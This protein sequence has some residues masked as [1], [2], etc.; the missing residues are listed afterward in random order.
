MHV[1]LIPYGIKSCVDML[2]KEM[3][4]QKFPLICKKEGEPDRSMLIQGSVR[5]SPFGLVEYVF[6]KESLDL[7]LHTF[8][9]DTVHYSQ[10]GW[11]LKFLLKFLKK[12][13]YLKEIPKY[14]KEKEF[15]WIRDNV[16]IMVLGIR[17]DGEITEP[18]GSSWPGFTHEAI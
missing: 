11:K 4:C 3:E 15:P 1:V 5:L 7:V 16:A 14:S 12:F 6:P 17:E 13:L 2:I 8:R 18:E 10:K 9:A